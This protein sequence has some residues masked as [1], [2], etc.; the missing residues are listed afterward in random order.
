MPTGRAL[1]VGTG[2]TRER[3]A[4]V[5]ESPRPYPV[6]FPRAHRILEALPPDRARR[7]QT[8]GQTDSLLTGLFFGEVLGEE[9]LGD[10]CTRGTVFGDSVSEVLVLSPVCHRV[11]I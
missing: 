11:R 3:L 7:T 10:V 9:N 2:V 5:R 6:R 4:L 8:P 1:A